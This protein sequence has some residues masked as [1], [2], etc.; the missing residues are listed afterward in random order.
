MIWPHLGRNNG[1]K[2][3]SICFAPNLKFAS[4][5]VDI[6]VYRR[7]GH[8]LAILPGVSG[9]ACNQSPIKSLHFTLI[10]RGSGAHC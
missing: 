6:L 7:V 5:C 2:S 4:V 9:N 8:A 10:P 1:F 3:L